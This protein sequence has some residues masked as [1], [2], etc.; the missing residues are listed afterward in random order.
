MAFSLTVMLVCLPVALLATPI[1]AASP[2]KTLKLERSHTSYPIRNVQV[3]IDPSKSLSIED[4]RKLEDKKVAEWHW[5][6]RLNFGYSPAR[7]WLKVSV[8]N[9]SS[10]DADWLLEFGYPLI[11]VLHVHQFIGSRQVARWQTGRL[12]AFSSRPIGYRN[13]LF[14]FAA[15]KGTHTDLYVM[16]ESVGTVLAPMAVYTQNE[17]LSQSAKK[18]TAIGMYCGIILAMVLY[19]FFLFITIRDRNYLFYVAYALTFCLLMTSLNGMTYQYLWPN[20][21]QWNKISVPVLAGICYLFLALFTKSFLETKKL[22]PSLDWGLDTILAGAIFLIVGGLFHYGLFVNRFT[23]LFIS[24]APLIALP[25]SLRCMQLGSR[26]ATYY[27]IAFGC[28]FIG[29]GTHAARDLSWLPQNFA[30]ENGPYLGS[31]AEMILLSLGMAVRVKLLKEEKVK[32]EFQA[33]EAERQLSENKKSLESHLAVSTLASQVAHDIRSPLAALEIVSGD[34]AQLPE[35]KRILVRAAVGRIRDIANNLLDRQRAQAKGTGN[36]LS[37]SVVSETASPRLLSSLIDPVVSEKRLQFRSLSRIEIELRLDAPSYGIF[38]AVQP[39]EFKR[40]VSNL[41]NNAVE[42]F[43]DSAGAVSVSLSAHDGRA[44][45]IVQDNGKG[46]PPE[47][48]AKLGQRS[49]THGKAGGSGLGLYHARS[50]AESW[51]GSLELASEVGKGTTATLSLPLA[52]APTW[53]VPELSL[54][55]GKAV[56]ILDDDESIH[57]VWQ[58]RLDALKAGAHGVQVVHVSTPAEMRGWVKNEA[59]A[60]CDALYL[61]DYELLGQRETGLALTEELGLGERVV[62]VTSRY[63]EPEVLE[64]CRRL[65]VRLIPKGLAG[66]VPIRIQ[67]AQ[68]PAAAT[69][70]EKDARLDAVLIDDDALARMNWKLAAKRAGKSFKAYEDA[71]SFWAELDAGAI[72]TD[73]PI[74]ID[75]NLPDGVKGEDVAL[76][77][78]RRGFA[79]IRLAT[80]HDPSTFAPMSHIREVIGK[81]PPWGTT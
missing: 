39:V 5:T 24:A 36:S 53:F 31:A 12:S 50:S 8:S 67:A 22:V 17:F 1:A 66:F 42:A 30:T 10:N 16:L 19:N 35:D 27:F 81:E 55:P 18:T 73:T 48:L 76:E 61:F 64:A 13:F 54:A 4:I 60:A 70:A 65:K 25:I 43:G 74:Y 15:P 41:V 32:S 11:Q 80:G 2:E 59:V 49:E 77:I 38:A 79:E 37:P 52:P 20:W 47:V 58:G 28:F 34:I 33:M 63:E 51:G 26:T 75:S 23:S 46:I 7:Y 40:L 71:A 29:S 21:Q 69:P 68:A 9:L 57:Q 44:L 72:S 62:L 14:N 56:V 45:V 6:Q 78:S 3:I